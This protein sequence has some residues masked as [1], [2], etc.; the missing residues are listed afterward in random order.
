[1]HKQ[2]AEQAA[3]RCRLSRILPGLHR[4]V[5]SGL[6]AAVAALLLLSPVVG[7]DLG[8]L[9]RPA[10]AAWAVTELPGG[11][12]ESGSLLELPQTGDPLL[13]EYLRL[14]SERWR[15]DMA[16]YDGLCQQILA[17]YGLEA[18]QADSLS[19]NAELDRLYTEQPLP[20]ELEEGFMN[21]GGFSAVLPRKDCEALAQQFAED[22]RVHE[23]LFE[24]ESR[25][26][27]DDPDCEVEYW[28]LDRRAYRDLA[29][30]AAAGKLRPQGLLLLTQLLSFTRD[31]YV[32]DELNSIAVEI[33]QKTSGFK[34]QSGYDAAVAA[35]LD[36]NPGLM[37]TREELGAEHTDALAI[38]ASSG[39]DADG[40]YRRVT[41]LAPDWA[42][43]WYL[44]AEHE[45]RA[46]RT[47]QAREALRR[48]NS[49]TDLSSALSYPMETIDPLA[50]SGR[51]EILGSYYFPLRTTFFQ[52]LINTSDPGWFAMRSMLD[53]SC[54]PRQK[55]ELAQELH[56]MFLRRARI[57]GPA[58]HPAQLCLSA[59]G[60]LQS[61]VQE[62]LAAELSPDALEELRRLH[63]TLR[64]FSKAHHEF[65]ELSLSPSSQQHQHDMNEVDLP[66]S[67]TGILTSMISL[68][69]S[70]QDDAQREQQF[71]DAQIGPLLDELAQFDYSALGLGTP[72]AV[73]AEQQLDGQRGQ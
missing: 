73:V 10:D 26:W 49:V 66:F 23:L 58:L 72:R 1:M 40:I 68:Y 47:E 32:E 24:M 36:E 44:L 59:E 19:L 12:L 57:S 25:R 56:Q 45:Q 22:P 13:D 28:Q 63:D 6:V 2:V 69:Q 61:K 31:D 50:R 70:T 67:G 54:E 7:A 29:A 15:E 42:E 51:A 64:T 30:A 33:E 21:T 20:P 4:P 62:Q 37:R 3:E 65:Q 48:G 17:H 60:K 46:G 53:D 16:E 39:M 71:C 38:L 43:G 52:T 41:E 55:L 34:G 27:L 35:V 8:S 9:P 5:A 18:L 14:L 11:E